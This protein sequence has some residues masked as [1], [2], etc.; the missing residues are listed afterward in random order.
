LCASSRQC[1]ISRFMSSS[2]SLDP[3]YFEDFSPSIVITLTD[4]I[5]FAKSGSR[6][7][8]SEE[9]QHYTCFIL[10]RNA[11]TR[12]KVFRLH[13]SPYIENLGC[14]TSPIMGTLGYYQGSPLARSAVRGCRLQAQ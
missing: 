14:G 10:G 3:R 1:M 9:F 6:T 5:F 8:R 2:Q 13:C 7:L 4:P 12:L 11:A